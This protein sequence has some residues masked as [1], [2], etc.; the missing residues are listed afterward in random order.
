MLGLSS[1]AIAACAEA[2]EDDASAG[3]G[4]CEP[5]PEAPATPPSAGGLAPRRLAVNGTNLNR[6]ALN[7]SNLNRI[8]LNGVVLNGI[9]LNGVALNR[10]ALNG[11]AATG[12]VQVEGA[13]ANELVA[14]A[15]SETL[16]GDAFVG[17]RIPGQGIDGTSIELTV[18]AFERSAAG[19]IA[20]YALEHEGVNLCGEPGAKG[21][22][23]AGIWD[24]RAAWHDALTVGGARLS[25]TFSCA[26]GVLAKCVTWGYAP[27]TVGADL[28]QSCT[29]MARADYC[30]DGRS[31]T[32][33]GTVID[34]QD[35]RGV[36]VATTGDAS[37]L[38]AGAWGPDG[39][40]CVART[41]YDARTPAGAPVLPSCWDALPKCASFAEATG[42]GATLGNA[43]RVQSRTL[44]E[45]E[46]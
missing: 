23:L 40:V 19:D 20:W 17:A 10:I 5:D 6:I 3:A 35:T 43:S 45:R 31:F 39:A 9:D 21:M 7:G 46:R 32:K 11:T 13:A 34:V 1:L 28:H 26:T 33:D 38:F 42:L 25:A 2:R 22:F 18:T 14:T 12:G 8:A 37:L 36:Q 30:G 29:R 24:E 15:G 16:A 27:W 44:C 41:R 4:A